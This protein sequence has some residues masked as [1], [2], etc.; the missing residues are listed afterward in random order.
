[1][2]NPLTHPVDKAR[3]NGVETP[4]LCE[5][6]GADSPRKWDERDG[7]GL[8]G[9]IVIFHGVGLSHF[10]IK[11]RLLTSE[12]WNAWA[13]FRPMVERP[14]LGKRARAMDVS[15]P[16]LEDLGIRAAVV[17]N[18]IGAIQTDDSEWTVEIKMIE[19]RRPKRSIS[20]PDGATATEEDP[21]EA[22]IIKPLRETFG[23]L[24]TDLFGS[25]GK[26]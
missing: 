5:I 19:F 6:V 7:Y 8:S 14:P 22:Q 24:A 3:I 11:L 17:E 10:S 9:A 18:V 1:M 13:K 21:I 4:G 25:N 26:P 23:S 2:M 16:Q 20:A 12:D 15:H